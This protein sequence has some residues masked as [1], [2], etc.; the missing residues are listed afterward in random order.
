MFDMMLAFFAVAALVSL[1]FTAQT[2]H[3][4]GFLLTGV[5]IGLGLLAKGPA[6][7]LHYLPVA[8]SAPWWVLYLSGSDNTIEWSWARWYTGVASSILCAI[9]IG[10]S[11][12]IPAGIEGGEVYR[13]AIFWGQSAGRIVNSF[14][15]ARPFWWYLAILPILILPW[16]I[17]PPV[18]RGFRLLFAGPIDGGHRLCIIW[19][20]A[21]FACFLW[22]TV[23]RP[24]TFSR[25]FL[26][27]QFWRLTY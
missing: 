27:W 16:F 8:I 5:L 22:L 26:P 23:N 14:A 7:L 3:W 15:H 11:W 1:V 18:W 21:A 25:N 17:W 12:A 6:I 9:A 19:F 2:G 10:L 4:A 24:T 13:D 20:A